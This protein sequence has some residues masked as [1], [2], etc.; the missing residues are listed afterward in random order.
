MK[1]NLIKSLKIFKEAFFFIFLVILV[2]AA[3]TNFMGRLKGEKPN[4]FGY[5]TLIV[6]SGSMEPEYKV[7]EFIIMKK[8]PFDSIKEGDIISFYYDIT[9]NGRKELVTHRVINIKQDGTLVTRGD[10]ASIYDTQDV[11]QSDFVGRIVYN[12]FTIGVILYSLIEYNILV[13]II[14]SFFIYLIVKQIK[15]IID[16]YIEEKHKDIKKEESN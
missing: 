3:S 11:K 6:V 8:V 10:N 13:L 1:K 4:L 16:I 15:R 12:S 5:S 9:G 7:R 14:A 2:L